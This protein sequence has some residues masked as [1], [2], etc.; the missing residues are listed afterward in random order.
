MT[1]LNAAPTLLRSTLGAD[2]RSLQI[3]L[4]GTKSNRAAIGVQAV[5]EFASGEKILR[6]ING[7]GS[8]LSSHQ[9]LL[10][11]EVPAGWQPASLTIDW[12]SGTV[13][14]LDANALAERELTVVEAL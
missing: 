11:F 9:P 14:Q 13:Q 5:L 8:Y 7:G 6:T 3:H 12:P 1:H 4:T 2:Q 10:H